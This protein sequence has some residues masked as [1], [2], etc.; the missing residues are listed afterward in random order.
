MYTSKVLDKFADF[1]GAPHKPAA[2]F[3][4]VQ[5]Q[6]KLTDQEKIYVGHPFPTET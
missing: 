3:R 4:I 2:A 1:F 6:G 5:D